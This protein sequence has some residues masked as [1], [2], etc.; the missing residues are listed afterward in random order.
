MIGELWAKESQGRARF[1]MVTNR[2]W[3]SIADLMQ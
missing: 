2:D 1:V 3:D